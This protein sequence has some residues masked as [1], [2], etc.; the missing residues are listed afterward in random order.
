[1]PSKTSASACA[2]AYWPHA[3]YRAGKKPRPAD[4]QQKPCDAAV[5]GTYQGRPGKAKRLYKSGRILRQQIVADFFCFFAF[6]MPAAVQPVNCVQ[7]LQQSGERIEKVKVC[8][9]AMQQHN[10]R[11]PPDTS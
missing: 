10:G 4:S 3:Y 7:R 11:P 6:S 2:G 5:A 1:M 9:V 8:T